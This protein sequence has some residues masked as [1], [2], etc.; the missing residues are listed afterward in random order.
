TND[1]EDPKQGPLG[2]TTIDVAIRLGF[3]GLLG[4]WSFRVI[5]PFLTI[6]LWSAI[7]VVALYPL[8][9]R[10]AL[11]LNARVAAAL[12]TLL[13]LMIVIGPVRWLGLGMLTGIRSLAVR[14]QDGQL[15]VPP[16][17]DFVRGWPIVGERLHELW[18]L[19]AINMKVALAETLPMLKPLGGTLLGI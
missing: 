3:I 15:E 13:G 11:R 4:Y 2:S 17:P 5:D 7:L 6:G 14:L 9:N 16:P 8:F 18:S 10:L 12:V 1:H 19:A